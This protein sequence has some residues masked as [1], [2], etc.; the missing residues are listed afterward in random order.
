M[1]MK[2]TPY[3]ILIVFPK[4]LAERIALVQMDRQRRLQLQ[5]DHRCC[6]VRPSVNFT[7]ILSADCTRADPKFSKK[8][9][10]SAVSFCAFGTYK[11]KSCA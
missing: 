5:G 7:N 10:K 8:T 4:L 6:L 3:W 11:R 1:L 9:V 2:L